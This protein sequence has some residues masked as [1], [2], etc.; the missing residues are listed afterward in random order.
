M[1]SLESGSLKPIFCIPACTKEKLSQKVG[2][3]LPW[4]KWS[5]QDRNV[6]KSEHQFRQFEQIYN[7]LK[8]AESFEI[9]QMT[10]CMEPCS[11]N[12]Y[13]FA[14]ASAEVMQKI[15]GKPTSGSEVNENHFF[16]LEIRM[17]ICFMQSRTSR[18][19]ENL[20]HS[21]SGYEK[22]TLLRIWGNHQQ[23]CDQGKKRQ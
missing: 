23:L 15:D 12:K 5:A 22:K 2:C 16:T 17:R 8:N 3:R 20:W 1:C 7:L 9:L 14:S 10:G 19:D 18:R 11:Y 13:S 6:C 21:I 4:D